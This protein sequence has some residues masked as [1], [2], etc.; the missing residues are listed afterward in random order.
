MKFSLRLKLNI[1]FLTVIIICGLVAA[2]VGMRLIVAGVINQAQDNVRNDLNSAREIYQQEAE[3]IKDVVRFTALRFFLK[4]EIL[5]NDNETLKKELDEIRKAESLDILTLTDKNGL[6]VVRARKSSVF[7]D[8]QRDDQLVSQVLLSNKVVVGTVI[9]KTEE[10]AKEGDDLAQLAYTEVASTPKA[11]QKPDVVQTSAM[12]I[13][14]VSPV[15][16]YDGELVGILYGCNLINR[17]SQL[18]DKIKETAYKGIKYRGIDIGVSTIFQ[19]DIRIATNVLDG[20][21]KRAIGTRMSKDVYE[22]VVKKSTPWINRAFVIDKWYIAAYEPIED[23]LGQIV[24]VLAVG[25]QEQEF[26]DIR[27]RTVV[28][29]LGIMFGGMIIA[30]IVSNMLAKSVLRPIKDLIHA[31]GQ[32]AK[33]NLDYRAKTTQT[34]EISQLGNTFNQMASSLKDRD[35]KLKEYADQQIMKSERLATL[36]QLAA[37]V[38]HEINNPLGAI[39]MYTHLSLEDMEEK[40]ILRKNLEKTVAEASRCKDIIRGL[41][42]FARQTEPKVEQIN[43]NDILERTLA[44]TKDQALFRNITI[45]KELCPFLPKILVDIG[46]MQQVFANIVLNAGDA[47]EGNGQLAVKTAISLDNEHIDIEFTDTGHGI[48]QENME[49]IFEPFFTTK[50]VGRGT[51]LGLAVSYGII[52][53][54]KGTIE[55]KSEPG[56]GTTFIIRLPIKQKEN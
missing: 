43:I 3:R 54:H 49:K 23:T 46:Q 50:E 4:D 40:D 41:L 20:N 30:V 28:T 2:L 33:G 7:G 10:L 44:V 14:A 29:F 53:R 35:E 27:N 36:G 48:E 26:V 31:S 18:V 55:V 34:D 25:M 11:R 51:G 38:A 21:G 1:S 24:G 13:K 52:T 15:F 47:M 17:N 32:W 19:G 5:A 22:Q 12:C 56:N 9:L 39:L 16:G 8:N 42:D 37:G 6:V 45:K